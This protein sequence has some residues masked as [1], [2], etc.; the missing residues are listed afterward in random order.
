MQGNKLWRNERQNAAAVK[1]LNK[2]INKTQQIQQKFGSIMETLKEN[3]DAMK[4]DFVSMNMMMG[5]MNTSI[6]DMKD[7]IGIE[8][9]QKSS[10]EGLFL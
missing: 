1:R 7:T 3:A 10:S 5:Q 6:N 4:E 8:S 2:T 9:S